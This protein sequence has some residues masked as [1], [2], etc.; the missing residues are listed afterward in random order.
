M[1]QKRPIS[2][3][4][5]HQTTGAVRRRLDPFRTTERGYAPIPYFLVRLFPR[6]LA[7]QRPRTGISCVHDCQCE[8]SERVGGRTTGEEVL[9]VERRSGLWL[10]IRSARGPGG[11]VDGLTSFIG[12]AEDMA[13]GVLESQRMRSETKLRRADRSSYRSCDR[14]GSW[15]GVAWNTRCPSLDRFARAIIGDCELAE[16][17]AAVMSSLMYMPS[18]PRIVN[19]TQAPS[20]SMT[21]SVTTFYLYSSAV[22]SRYNHKI[23]ITSILSIYRFGAGHR[24]STQLTARANTPA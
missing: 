14:I 9:I 1:R 8:G 5:R 6:C 22:R 4:I 12:T 24:R 10:R 7:G 17:F 23:T 16:L 3:F 19:G 20:A 11:A 15:I 2:G 18:N 21:W 13:R